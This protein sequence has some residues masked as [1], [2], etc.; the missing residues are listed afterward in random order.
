MKALEEMKSL[1]DCKQEYYRSPE[2]SD[3]CVAALVAYAYRGEAVILGLAQVGVKRDFLAEMG[4][5]ILLP[6]HKGRGLDI[7]KAFV[8]YSH[9]AKHGVKVYIVGEDRCELL[10]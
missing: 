9:A 3:E 1:E 7:T 5:K 4:P 8:L 2:L 10:R 6:C